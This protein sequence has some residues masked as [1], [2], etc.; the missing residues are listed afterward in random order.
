[1]RKY[2]DGKY[3]YVPDEP[4][5]VILPQPGP[6]LEEK[7][8]EHGAKIVTLEETL[9]VLYGGIYSTTKLKQKNKED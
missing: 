9:D 2:I 7:V 6:T 1:M 4:P 8:A 3:V 5:E